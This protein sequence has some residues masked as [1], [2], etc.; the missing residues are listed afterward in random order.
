MSS[1]D[2]A[3]KGMESDTE[4]SDSDRDNSRIEVDG[5]YQIGGAEAKV[6]DAMSK[7]R[8]NNVASDVALIREIFVHIDQ[9]SKRIMNNFALQEECHR[10]TV[11]NTGVSES[12]KTKTTVCK[13]P[14][15]VNVQAEKVD[16][17]RSDVVTW[18]QYEEL[19]DGQRAELLERSL[20]I[21]ANNSNT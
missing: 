5:S 4:T 2:D 9:T 10:L 18:S 15:L 12:N 1:D 13:A 11:A 8:E 3:V 16:Q 20:Q 21:L 7:K 14:T 6:A 17:K 19:N